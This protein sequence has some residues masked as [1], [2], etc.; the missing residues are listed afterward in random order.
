MD[1]GV[2]SWVAF[3]DNQEGRVRFGAVDRAREFAMGGDFVPFSLK[4][5]TINNPL[6][7]VTQLHL[8]SNMDASS[9]SGHQIG[10]TLNSN[11]IRLIGYNNYANSGS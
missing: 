11:T 3:I 9:K 8:S 4:F 7:I 2:S 5:V 1:L 6:D 10:I